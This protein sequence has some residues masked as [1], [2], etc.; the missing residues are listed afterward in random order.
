M[1]RACWMQ[2]TGGAVTIDSFRGVSTVDGLNEVL[3]AREGDRVVVGC[4][5][6]GAA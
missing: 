6:S 4:I 3:T 1:L 5:D 2:Q